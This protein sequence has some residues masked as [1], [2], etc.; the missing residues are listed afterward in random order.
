MADPIDMESEIAPY[1]TGL[2]RPALV[3]AVLDTAR[4]FCRRTHIYSADLTAISVVADD[5]DYALTPPSG[6][7]I[8]G[9]DTV[10]FKATGA[11]NDQY[12]YLE[13]MSKRE[14][15]NF[16]QHAWRYSE[17][18]EPEKFYVS[19]A[20]VLFLYPIPTVAATNG[21]LVTCSMRPADDAVAYPDILEDNWKAAMRA[22]TLAFLFS[23]K[24]LPWYDPQAAV[25]WAGMFD[26]QVSEAAWDKVMG[27]GTT[28]WEQKVKFP[29]FA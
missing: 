23:Q 4:E 3:K 7:K 29:F 6:Y 5:Y 26:E 12:R 25:A 14:M 18:P 27:S 2:D 22:G 13:P 28:R 17:A 1:I 21:I 16:L 10:Q 8:L 15:E 9:V 20:M 24:A 19:Q 11:D